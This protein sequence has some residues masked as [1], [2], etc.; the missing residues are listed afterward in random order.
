M[1]CRQARRR[2]NSYVSKP[3][4]R[5]QQA[6]K[7]ASLIM[8]TAAAATTVPGAVDIAPP[9]PPA[10]VNGGGG[11]GGAEDLSVVDRRNTT[12][13]IHSLEEEAKSGEIVWVQNRMKLIRGDW[14]WSM[15][16]VQI[17]SGFLK[18]TTNGRLFAYRDDNAMLQCSTTFPQKWDEVLRYEKLPFPSIISS[19]KPQYTHFPCSCC[20]TTSPFATNPFANNPFAGF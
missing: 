10:A 12:Q 6:S 17:T 9:P 20:N 18:S 15:A 3:C 5:D 13:R 16:H 19:S 1:K 4:L 2:S 14:A 8:A 7:Q 11:G